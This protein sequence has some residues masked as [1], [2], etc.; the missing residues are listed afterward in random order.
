M[1]TTSYSDPRK[2]LADMLDAV[3]ADHEPVVITRDE[4]KPS[5][6]R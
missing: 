4:A 3:N 2:N 5:A 6:V 1:R